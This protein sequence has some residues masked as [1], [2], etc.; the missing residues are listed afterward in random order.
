MTGIAD[1]AN[2]TNTREQFMS[3][4]HALRQDLSENPGRWENADLDSFLQALGHGYKT[5]TDIS[6]FGESPF[7]R[8]IGV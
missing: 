8:R 5:W 6:D 2:A 7:R 4:L 3:F 1:Q